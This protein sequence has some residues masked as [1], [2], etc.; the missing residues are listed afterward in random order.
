MCFIFYINMYKKKHLKG[1]KDKGQYEK[2][3]TMDN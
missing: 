1:K 3:C 2:N